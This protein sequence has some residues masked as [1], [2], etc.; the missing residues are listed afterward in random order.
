MLTKWLAFFIVG[1]GLAP[2]VLYVSV[3]SG[4]H[5]HAKRYSRSAREI[6]KPTVSKILLRRDIVL[7][8]V[9]NFSLLTPDFI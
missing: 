2:A 5:Y 6:L 1:Q 8:T 3:G 4:N 7:R 9:N